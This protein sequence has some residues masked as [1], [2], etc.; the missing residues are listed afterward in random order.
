ML[1]TDVNSLL[2]GRAECRS[3]CTVPGDWMPPSGLFVYRN[4]LNIIHVMLDKGSAKT[5][6]GLCYILIITVLTSDSPALHES[7]L[8]RSVISTKKW[9]YLEGIV[10]LLNR[11]LIAKTTDK[12]SQRHAR[13]SM[14]RA[15]WNAGGPLTFLG[16]EPPWPLAFT[17]Y[18]LP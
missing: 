17:N 14:L 12:K 16:R 5:V 8:T 7:K 13:L 10:C 4:L 3:C 11:L 2:I 9:N 6:I 15:P 1:I 18:F